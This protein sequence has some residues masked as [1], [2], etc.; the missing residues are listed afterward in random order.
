MLTFAQL[1]S[2]LECHPSIRMSAQAVT[3]SV[4]LLQPLEIPGAPVCMAAADGH[5][6]GI[7]ILDLKELPS[8]STPV[9][10]LEA[11]VAPLSSSAPLWSGLDRIMHDIQFFLG[12]HHQRLRDELSSL[13]LCPCCL[14][15]GAQEGDEELLAL[16][17]S[18]TL[19]QLEEETRR[20]VLVCLFFFFVHSLPWLTLFFPPHSATPAAKRC[21]CTRQSNAFPWRCCW[22][23]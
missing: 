5:T 16:P 6:L 23:L 18:F 7:S 13:V 12:L 17:G 3:S 11:E 8:P 10:L 9:D 2:F 1:Q 21:P 4:C 14:R 15:T 19:A 20:D 22:R